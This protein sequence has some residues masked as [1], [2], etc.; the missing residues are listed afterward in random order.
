MTVFLPNFKGFLNIG[1]LTSFRKDNS[2]HNFALLTVL[3]LKKY[4]KSLL[5]LKNHT[6]KLCNKQIYL[7]TILKM[8]YDFIPLQL[9]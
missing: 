7:K 8:L 1:A 3:C 2:F 6:G 9:G 4:L 5:L